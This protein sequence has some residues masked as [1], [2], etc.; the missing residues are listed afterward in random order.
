MQDKCP[1]CGETLITKTIKKELGQGSID[2]PVSQTCPK[3]NWNKDLTGAAD[4]ISKPVIVKV[5]ETKK[6]NVKPPSPP[7]KA[8]Q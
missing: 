8:P 3:C 6:E 2:Y 1:K 7:K 4:I 5:E